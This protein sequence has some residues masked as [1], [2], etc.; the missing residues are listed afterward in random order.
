[1]SLIF[2]NARAMAWAG[3]LDLTTAT[4]KAALLRP[5]TSVASEIDA[6]FLSDFS[7]LEE[8]TLGGYAR[9][10]LTTPAI[11]DPGTGL[12]AFKADDV[13]FGVLS[14]SATIGD[15]VG[16]ILLF[17]AN[18]SPST[19]VPLAWIDSVDPASIAFP[20][21]AAGRPLSVTWAGGVVLSL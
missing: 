6:K 11:D 3:S 2:P 18:G 19:D 7:A 5:A 17:V 21:D 4:I 14:P 8:V 12:V 16:G 15:S 13:A 20:Y 9:Q 1:M 10:T